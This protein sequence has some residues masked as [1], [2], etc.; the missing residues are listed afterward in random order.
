MNFNTFLKHFDI[1]KTIKPDIKDDE[2]EWD[3][4]D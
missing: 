3:W 4:E 2:F 1:Y